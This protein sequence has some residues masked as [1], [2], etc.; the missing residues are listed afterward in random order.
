M[1]YQSVNP[2]RFAGKALILNRL[3]DED[4]IVMIDGLTAG[5]IGFK[6]SHPKVEPEKRLFCEIS[7]LAF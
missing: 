2:R 7:L 3:A 5:R 4:L 6:T 1:V